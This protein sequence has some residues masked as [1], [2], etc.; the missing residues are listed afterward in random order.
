[1][2]PYS[3][4]IT[5]E[6]LYGPFSHKYT[7][8][9]IDAHHL[10]PLFLQLGA[11]AAEGPITLCGP[12]V[13]GVSTDPFILLPRFIKYLRK[14]AHDQASRRF[15]TGVRFEP[16]EGE[17]QPWQTHVSGT[18]DKGAFTLHA[19]GTQALV[20]REGDDDPTDL[21]DADAPAI[22]TTDGRYVCRFGTFKEL[23]KLD[24]Q[25]LVEM[26]E[27]AMAKDHNLVATAIE[28][29][30]EPPPGQYDGPTL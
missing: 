6:G 7:Y 29:T 1:M 22:E 14:V 24:V 15:F 10:H 19:H 21:S 16:N 9:I 13:D 17:P 25:R 20:E 23:F 26:C 4:Q 11:R 8:T 18:D 28:H 5:I 12:D 3:T 30:A 27:E 2:R